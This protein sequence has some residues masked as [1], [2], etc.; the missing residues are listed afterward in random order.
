[1]LMLSLCD[2]NFVYIFV[3]GTIAITGDRAI[4]K[5]CA[6]FSDYIG[7]IS[8]TQMD[9]AKYIDVIIPMYVIII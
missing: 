4:F 8:N 3:K 7:K 9:N 5:N 1:M 6:S 2:Y